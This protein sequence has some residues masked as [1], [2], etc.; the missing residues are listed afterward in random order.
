MI[1]T[2]KINSSSIH[3]ANSNCSLKRMERAAGWHYPSFLW[4]TLPTAV[5]DALRE[6][7]VRILS[8]YITRHLP[9]HK[10]CD[11]SLEDALASASLSIIVPVHDA[12]E[13]TRRCLMSLQKYAPKAEIILVDD[14][15]KLQE[16]SELLEDF[17][18]RNRWKLIRHTEPLGHSVA[19]G[20]G[21]TLA[22]RTYLCLLNSDT[23]VTP[24]C[25]RPITQVFEDNPK[26]G[27]AGPSTSYAGTEQAL[28]LAY[29]TRHYLN[30]SQIYE[31]AG[32]LVTEFSGP[33]LTDL[34]YVDG[35]AFFI[36]RSLW[37]QLG[38]FDRNIPD[39]GN[40]TELCG[41]VLRTGYRAVWVRNSYIHHFG[42]TSYNKAI[43]KESVWAHIR[44]A[45]DYI[46]QKYG[47]SD[48]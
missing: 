1:Q 8:H 22:T 7:R 3:A 19:C 38:G 43:G 42:G 23:V 35:F 9:R 17:S 34:P 6:L 37:K 45:N 41:R 27:V 4:R 28:P 46:N 5:K 26:I 11:Q 14:G 47:G 30:D 21:A 24:W 13:V 18:S 10:E 44:A 48:L 25:W 12:P 31:Y 32:R 16:T 15:S 2:D 36:R 39:Y 40:E 20:A 33:T 29:I